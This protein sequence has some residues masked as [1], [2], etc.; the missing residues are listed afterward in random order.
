[1]TT[2]A[3]LVAFVEHAPP[4]TPSKAAGLVGWALADALV[5]DGCMGRA[6]ARGCMP[7]GK[8]VYADHPTNFIW[9]CGV[10]GCEVNERKGGAV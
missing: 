10:C 3:E 1:M 8:P 5:C 4:A 6:F 2:L 9:L 7:K